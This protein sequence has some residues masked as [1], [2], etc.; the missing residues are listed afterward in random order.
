MQKSYESLGKMELFFCRTSQLKAPARRA[1][2][3]LDSDTTKNSYHSTIS[4]ASMAAAVRISPTQERGL[5]DCRL[6]YFFPVFSDSSRPLKLLKF[7][8]QSLPGK[9]E[10]D[11]G[12]N[13]ANIAISTAG[14]ARVVQEEC[15]NESSMMYVGFLRP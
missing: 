7:R 9:L 12:K 10:L 14:I 2:K 3:R 5:F 1:S 13:P 8:L 15:F 4:E 11:F 6:D